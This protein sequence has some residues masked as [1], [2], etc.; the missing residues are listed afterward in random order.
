[1]DHHGSGTLYQENHQIV[2]KSILSQLLP[3][4]EAI[5]LYRKAVA[6]PSRTAKLPT[7]RPPCSEFQRGSLLHN[8]CFC[9]HCKFLFN[10]L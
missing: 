3:E 5:L 6:S 8:Y 1:V 9:F 2:P 4:N 7:Q 10:G